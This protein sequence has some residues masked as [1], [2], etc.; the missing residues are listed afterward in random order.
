M[1]TL[2][3]DIGGTKFTLALFEGSRLAR[4]E[5]RSTDRQGGRD[6]KIGRAHV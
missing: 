1:N 4:R 5:S 6:W 2:A 3:I